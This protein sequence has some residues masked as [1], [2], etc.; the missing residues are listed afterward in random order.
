MLVYILSRYFAKIKQTRQSYNLYYLSIKPKN[1]SGEVSSSSVAPGCTNL[2][3][4]PTQLAISLPEQFKVKQGVEISNQVDQTVSA[5]TL[6][7]DNTIIINFAQPVAPGTL[8]TVDLNGVS[9]SDYLG[10]TWL[11]SVSGKSLGMTANIPIG[12]TQIQTY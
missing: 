11:L 6:N 7:T 9:T 8:L 3:F 1:G 2:L 12:I 5:T 4:S 10:R